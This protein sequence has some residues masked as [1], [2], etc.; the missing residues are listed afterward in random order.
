MK[1]Y[2]S[3]LILLSSVHILE[4]NA[5][6][7][8][9]KYSLSNFEDVTGLEKE[10]SINGYLMTSNAGKIF[11]LN[12]NGIPV[13]AIQ[14]P[15]LSSTL[16]STLFSLGSSETVVETNNLEY[17]FGGSTDI[18]FIDAT[19]E[20]TISWVNLALGG[21]A[22]NSLR[23]LRYNVFPNYSLFRGAITDISKYHQQTKRNQSELSRGR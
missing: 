23:Y 16:N 20:G 6:S 18:G 4:L 8:Q 13:G 5:Q 9:K 2:L 1:K 15:G 19:D 12:N 14:I 3:L 11:K 22:V 17:I 7:F 10:S 21:T